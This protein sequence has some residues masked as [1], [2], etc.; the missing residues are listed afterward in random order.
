MPSIDNSAAVAN[1]RMDGDHGPSPPFPGTDVGIP[2]VFVVGVAVIV[3]V[4]LGDAVP[5]GIVVGFAVQVAPVSDCGTMQPTVSADGSAAFAGVGMKLIFTVAGVPALTVI[6]PGVDASCCAVRPTTWNG[7]VGD[8]PPPGAGL[9]TVTLTV[10]AVAV[11]AAVIEAFTC[12]ALTKV[13]VFAVPLKFSTD[14][15]LKFV[16]VT[17]SVTEAPFVAL[18]GESEVIVGTGLFTLNTVFPLVPPPGAGLLTETFNVRAVAICAAVT[19]TVSCVALTKIVVPAVPLRFTTEEETKF[20]PFTVSVKAAP[21]ASVLAGES[22][23]IVGR[24]LLTVKDC[25]VEGPDVGAGF[26]TVT[27]N[28]PAVTISATVI[29]AVTCVALTK[30]VVRE[31]PLKVTVAPDRNPV[32]LTVSVKAAPPTVAPAGESD[33]MVGTG[34]FT[35][36]GE[37][38]DVPPPGGAFVTVTLLVPAAAISGAVIAAVN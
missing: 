31:L 3:R 30:V 15:A 33:V 18:A 35:A 1:Q 8:V 28:V 38:P 13:V 27:L 16:P 12:V 11:S 25:A 34:L 2:A 26:D 14:D 9:A 17:V 22:D 29:A 37:F 4:V 32:P 19:E 5:A 7:E 23:V 21:P 36:N 10:P 24:G 20:V 6:A